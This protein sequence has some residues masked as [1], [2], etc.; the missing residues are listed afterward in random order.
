MEEMKRRD[1]IGQHNQSRD[2]EG[3]RPANLG[4]ASQYILDCGHYSSGRGSLALSTQ[5]HAV[6]NHPRGV[7]AVSANPFPSSRTISMGILVFT[8]AR[9]YIERNLFL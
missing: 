9:S 1:D 8:G 3:E 6:W 4:Q 7:P 2:V 5:L